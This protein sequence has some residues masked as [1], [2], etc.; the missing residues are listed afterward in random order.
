MSFQ[1]LDFVNVMA[2]DVYWTG[3]DFSM[4]IE[5]LQALGIPKERH[6]FVSPDTQNATHTFSCLLYQK[7]IYLFPFYQNLFDRESEAY[8]PYSLKVVLMFTQVSTFCRCK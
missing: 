1:Y 3:Y 6:Y 7:D 4:D 2:Y 5:A 8:G